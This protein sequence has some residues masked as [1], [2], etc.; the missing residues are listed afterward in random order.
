MK[1]IDK[2]FCLSDDS[3]NVYGYRLLTSGLRLERFSPAIGYL[4]HARDKGVAVRWED[5]RI[6]DGSLF[7]KPVVNDTVFPDLAEQIE[8]GF[9]AAASVGHIVAL[10]MTDDEG[11]RLE[12]QTGPTVLEWFPRECSIVDIPGNYNAIAKL[13]DESGSELMD[14]SD[15]NSNNVI[16]PKRMD[17]I[18]LTAAD[19]ALLNLTAPDVAAKDVSKRLADLVAKA[20]RADVLAQEIADLK[21]SAVAEKVRAV[22]AEGRKAGKLTNLL[23]A[24]LEKDY[25][26]N[27]DGLKA[28]VDSMSVQVRVTDRPGNDT[29]PEK[30]QGKT[31]RDLYLSGEL[32]DV[33]K[34]Y[35]AYYESLKMKE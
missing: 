16:T 26:G 27:P 14:L 2:E 21:A 10:K 22:I 8:N 32:E 1:K 17:R 13:Y 3:L 4:M 23:A 24:Q 18:E 29:V 20:A 34:N 15:N 19:L 25:A 33:K 35:P 9:Y 5:F 30:Y 12:G 6:A 7:A 31:L 28:L 11:Y